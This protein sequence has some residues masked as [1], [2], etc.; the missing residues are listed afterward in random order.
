MDSCDIEY[1]ELEALFEHNDCEHCPFK[2]KYECRKAH[3]KVSENTSKNYY[4]YLYS[5][6]RKDR[7]KL[8]AKEKE[9]IFKALKHEEIKKLLK[10]MGVKLA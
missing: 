4:D 3:N 10:E 6:N 2:S 8:T 5:M 7:R 1:F 9:T